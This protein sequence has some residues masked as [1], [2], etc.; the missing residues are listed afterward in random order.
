MSTENRS[1][2][3]PGLLLHL[4]IDFGDLLV[5]RGDCVLKR[6]FLRSGVLRL[7]LD[8][9]VRRLKLIKRAD[10]DPWRSGNAGQRVSAGFGNPLVRLSDRLLD[11][12]HIAKSAIDRFL[13][14]F[15]RRLGVRP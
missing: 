5:C 3:L 6:E 7:V 2:A 9:D 10:G 4:F 13:Q 15:Q 11:F 1:L 8:N 12:L 14:R